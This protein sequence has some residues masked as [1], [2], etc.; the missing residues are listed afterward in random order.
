MK[1]P[2]RFQGDIAYGETDPMIT[3]FMGE[4]ET[5]EDGKTSIRQDTR[6][7]VQMK[8]SE[9]AGLSDLV[10]A[11]KLDGIRIANKEAEKA[12]IAKRAKP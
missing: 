9:L 8:L 5:D 1:H 2:W 12:A 4:V 11:Q 3:V 10:N 6:Y 7:P